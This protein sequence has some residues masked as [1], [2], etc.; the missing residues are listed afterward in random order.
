VIDVLYLA[1]LIG[2]F[3]VSAALV[4][5]FERLRRPS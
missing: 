3:A 4:Y 2:F 1:M 5:G